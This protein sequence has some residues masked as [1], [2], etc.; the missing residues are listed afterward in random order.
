MI[1]H[2]TNHQLKIA[3]VVFILSFLLAQTLFSSD[4][5][6]ELS[7]K[8]R[9]KVNNYYFGND[10]QISSTDN[11][12][13]EINGKVK[14]LYDKLNIFDIISQIP[15]VKE[16]TDDLIVNDSTVPDK[17]IEANIT[18][19]IKVVKS[20]LEPDRIQVHVD[21]GEVILTGEVSFYR[22]KLL[23]ETIASWQE[24]VKGISN[25]IQVLPLKKAVSDDNLKLEFQEILRNKFSLNNEVTFNVQDGIVTL[26]GTAYSLWDKK[27]IE[28]EFYRV[29]GVKKVINSLKVKELQS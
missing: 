23:A 18:S 5:T 6:R 9:T 14:T 22:E 25:E 12:R 29:I 8:V 27:Q 16:I 28:K 26:S 17:L 20:I 10:F 3:G 7:E 2:N 15:G 4:A 21:D 13:V 11:G 1:F 19:E 24:G